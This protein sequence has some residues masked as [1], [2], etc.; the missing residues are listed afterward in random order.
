MTLM[1][2]ADCDGQDWSPLVGELMA[3]MSWADYVRA[4]DD[5]ARTR[6]GAASHGI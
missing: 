4:D 1:R 2:Y 6:K 5:D 3:H